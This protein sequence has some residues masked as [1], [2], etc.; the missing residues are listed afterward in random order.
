MQLRSELLAA[1]ALRRITQDLQHDN[2]NNTPLYYLAII[3]EELGEATKI[4]IDSKDEARW[5]TLDNVS[6]IAL[7]EELTDV[8]ASAL[9]ML[10]RLWQDSTEH[11][12]I[13]PADYQPL[14]LPGL[15]L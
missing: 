2:T 9:K 13:T 5:D 11:K 1:I 4:L 15:P 8:A 7:N 3:T 12:R 14:R 6:R 10:E